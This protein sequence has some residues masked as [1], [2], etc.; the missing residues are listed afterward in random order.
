VARPLGLLAHVLGRTDD[1]IAH[2][3]LGIEIDDRTGA[4]PFAAHGRRALAQVLVERGAAGDVDSA[5]ELLAAARGTYQELGMD[6]DTAA[7]GRLH[8]AAATGAGPTS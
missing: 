1:A 6:S 2:L 4:R 7:A 5:Q 8:A 3:R